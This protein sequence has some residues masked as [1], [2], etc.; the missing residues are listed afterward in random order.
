MLALAIVFVVGGVVLSGI[1]SGPRDGGDRADSGSPSLPPGVDPREG[2]DVL[3]EAGYRDL[4][5]AIEDETGETEV[6]DAVL[7]PTYAVGS[8]PLDASSQSDASFTWDGA[9]E[10]RDETTT[11]PYARIDL[12]TVD[13]AVILR[14]LDRAR[15]RVDQPTAWYATVRAPVGRDPAVIGAYASNEAG[16]TAYL[17]A[18][19]T[20]RV[21]AVRP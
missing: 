17:G 5:E 20:G 9:L 15:A 11:S 2:L 13:P 7:Y 14:L 6:F 8:L 1:V 4:L 21:T 19:R 16:E 3:S 10:T 12:A 18:T